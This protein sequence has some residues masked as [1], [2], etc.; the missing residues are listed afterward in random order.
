MAIGLFDKID[1]Q[2]K[3][4]VEIR[5][6][7]KNQSTTETQK[8]DKV[9]VFKVTLENGEEFFMPY[10]SNLDIEEVVCYFFED[11]NYSFPRDHYDIEKFC[12]EIIKSMTY[13]YNLKVFKRI[14]SSPDPEDTTLDDVLGKAQTVLTA[15]LDL[16]AKLSPLWFGNPVSGFPMYNGGNPRN[17]FGVDHKH[18]YL[19]KPEEQFLSKKRDLIYSLASSKTP[20]IPTEQYLVECTPMINDVNAAKLA[21]KKN[22]E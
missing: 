6:N 8:E 21:S 20:V 14:T 5:K 4:I 17:I 15:Q 1:D 19:L 11:K 22:Y 3:S 2:I 10:D 18:D 12:S 9:M 13:Y 16:A 7:D